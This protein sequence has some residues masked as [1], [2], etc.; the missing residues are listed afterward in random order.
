MNFIIALLALAAI[1]AATVCLSCVLLV[2]VAARW[3]CR[4]VQRRVRAR[5]VAR[6]LRELEAGT[7]DGLRPEQIAYLVEVCWDPSAH[8]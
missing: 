6:E 2:C 3:V 5:R 8:C 1:G 7:C 4:C